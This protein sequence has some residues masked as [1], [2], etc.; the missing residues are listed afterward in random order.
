MRLDFILKPDILACRGRSA[1]RLSGYGH[2]FTLMLVMWAVMAAAPLLRAASTDSG[3][4][5]HR[6]GTA[7]LYVRFCP[8]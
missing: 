3:D 7:G 1:E 8:R 6:L 5:Y 4:D 2:A